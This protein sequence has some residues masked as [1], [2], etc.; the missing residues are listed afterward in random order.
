ME[1]VPS[2]LPIYKAPTTSKWSYGAPFN[3]FITLL[4]KGPHVPPFLTINNG[5]TNWR[6]CSPILIGTWAKDWINS[7]KFLGLAE[8][9]VVVVVVD[10]PLKKGGEFSMTYTNQKTIICRTKRKWYRIAAINSALLFWK[11]WKVW[12][13]SESLNF[14]LISWSLQMGEIAQ[15]WRENMWNL[16]KFLC[17]RVCMRYHD[18]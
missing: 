6:S 4:K 2:Q 12:E 11:A 3:G 15:F 16:Q 1:F 14:F 9:F 8:V 10:P 5:P 17:S 7:W 18:M 13:N